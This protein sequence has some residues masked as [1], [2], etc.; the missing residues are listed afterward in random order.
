MTR[1]FNHSTEQ[2]EIQRLILE[3]AI[4]IINHSGG[5]DS[6]ATYLRCTREFNIPDSQ[7]LVVHA[8]IPDQDWVGLEQHIHDTVHHDTKVVQAIYK[9]GSLKD[10]TS[11]VEAKYASKPESPCFPS[12]N[13]RWCTSELKTQPISKWIKS[14]DREHGHK[15]FV[16]VLGI[17][18]DESNE[19]GNRCAFSMAQANY[20]KAD[21]NANGRTVYEWYP[22]FDWTYAET[23]DY[24]LECGEEPFWTYGEGVERCS[25]KF[26]IYSTTQDLK[27]GAR[28]APEDF[29]RMNEIEIRTGYALSFIHK[30]LKLHEIIAKATKKI[31]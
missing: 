3:G 21:L 11:R 14:L 22:I 23:M 13:Q 9:D 10:F 29:D 16:N 31:A 24:I 8:R 12:R 20:K 2:A 6:Q 25:C 7:I 27:I 30:G 4:F 17:R 19:R 5:K 15:L 18:A 28:L 26:C 1:T